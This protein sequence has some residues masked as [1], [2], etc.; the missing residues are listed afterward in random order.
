[1]TWNLV[2][3]KHNSRGHDHADLGCFLCPGQRVKCL[4]VGLKTKALQP[5]FPHCGCVVRVTSSYSLVK[6]EGRCPMGVPQTWTSGESPGSSENS[7][8]RLHLLSFCRD[9][10]LTALCEYEGWVYNKQINTYELSQIILMWPEFDLNTCILSFLKFFFF[11]FNVCVCVC[12]CVCDP[13]CAQCLQRPG[14]GVFLTHWN[15]SYRKSWGTVWVLGI[16]SRLSAEANVC[17]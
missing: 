9:T 17:S 14:G 16:E 8:S 1:V 5:P 12:V 4:I 13:T 2:Y 15:W 11:I 7:F 3:D 6:E 10:Y